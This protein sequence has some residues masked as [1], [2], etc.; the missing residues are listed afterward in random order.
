MN[1]S[2]TEL[3]QCLGNVADIIQQ[4]SEPAVAEMM[5]FASEQVDANFELFRRLA[6]ARTPWEYALIQA[7]FINSSLTKLTEAT[8]IAMDCW[9][10]A[11]RQC[12]DTL[13][14][15]VTPS[16]GDAT[17]DEALPSAARRPAAG[18]RN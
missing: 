7:F 1:T 2:G 5:R 14:G 8:E 13:S 3:R 6:T 16:K 12:G 4:D 11:F 18:T 10:D 9:V 17:Q 15:E